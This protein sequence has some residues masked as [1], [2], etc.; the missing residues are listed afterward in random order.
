MNN[1]VFPWVL[2]VFI[3]SSHTNAAYMRRRTRSI[4]FQVIPGRV[5]GAKALTEPML[6]YCQVDIQEQTSV[7]FEPKYK[8]F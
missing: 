5:F 3:N 1:H 8:T 4:L 2:I 6:D 7:K